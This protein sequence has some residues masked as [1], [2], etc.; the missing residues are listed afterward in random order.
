MAIAA[1]AGI[2]GLT[3]MT[4]IEITRRYIFDIPTHWSLEVGELILLFCVFLGMAYT[5][6]TRGH[7]SVDIVYRR[8]SK[9]GK[10]LA[11]LIMALPSLC[12][13]TILTWKAMEKAIS[14]SAHGVTSET[15]LAVPKLYP[16]IIIFIGGL[17]ACLQSL[18]MLYDAS[19]SLKRKEFIETSSANS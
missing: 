9:Q 6:Q 7:V 10:R 3:T 19:A 4:A 1:G 8:Y 18:L 2:L 16:M 11:D 5:V 14:Y 15:L 17:A 13:W 12:F